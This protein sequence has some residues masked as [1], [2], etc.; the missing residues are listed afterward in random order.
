MFKLNYMAF[1]VSCLSDCLA[2]YA[3]PNHAHTYHII[4]CWPKRLEVG[5]KNAQLQI[6]AK[7]NGIKCF[8]NLRKYHKKERTFDLLRLRLFP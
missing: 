8:V 7:S 6:E 5:Y 2:V 3:N 4:D 1:F